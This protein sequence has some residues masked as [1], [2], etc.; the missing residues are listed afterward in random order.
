MAREY[1][2]QKFLR[3]TGPGPLEEYIAR[4]GWNISMPQS[5]KKKEFGVDADAIFETLPAADSKKADVEFRT[6]NEPATS[7]GVTNTI[8]HGRWLGTD[9][10]SAFETLKT[11]Q[12]K[13]FRCFLDL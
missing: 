5:R 13:T 8:E 12:E 10:L 1:A 3:L 4:N 2:R 6:I 11:N 7:N 9:I